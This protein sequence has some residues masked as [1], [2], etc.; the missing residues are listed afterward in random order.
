ME[1]L[2]KNFRAL[3]KTAEHLGKAASGLELEAGKLAVTDAKRTLMA[4]LREAVAGAPEFQ[5]PL[6]RRRLLAYFSNPT[7]IL[8]DN[9]RIIVNVD[10]PHSDAGKRWIKAQEEAN[11]ARLTEKQLNQSP[12][13]KATFWRYKV[14]GSDPYAPTIRERFSYL[15]PDD[16]PFWYFL[17]YGTGINATP[18][19]TGSFFLRKTRRSVEG[20]Q[21]FNYYLGLLTEEFVKKTAD[22]LER[23]YKTKREQRVVWS[24]WY[25]TRDGRGWQRHQYDSKTGG[26][27][28]GGRREVVLGERPS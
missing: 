20:G 28:K 11:E 2:L 6:L 7:R 16:A 22:A 25:P 3:A 27:I 19:L 1:E 15:E 14:Y 9:K 18:S 17:E 10:N 4:N 24:K 26:Y 21:L 13:Q 12:L 23:G 5:H 8:F